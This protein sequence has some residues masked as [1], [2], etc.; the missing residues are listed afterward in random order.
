MLVNCIFYGM[1]YPTAVVSRFE[2]NLMTKHRHTHT[3]THTHI[4]T[5]FTHI[6]V[7]VCVCMHRHA[8]TWKHTKHAHTYY[9]VQYNTIGQEFW[10]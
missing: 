5:M 10:L 4:H 3:H 1:H 6:H 8:Q 2:G 9:N 7:H